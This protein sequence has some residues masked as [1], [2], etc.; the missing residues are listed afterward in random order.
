MINLKVSHLFQYV[1]VPVII[2]MI[3]TIL[4]S[5]HV[6]D[7]VLYTSRY[8]IEMEHYIDG[9]YYKTLDL[10]ALQ[11]M[12]CVFLTVCEMRTWLLGSRGKRPNSCESPGSVILL[13]CFLRGRSLDK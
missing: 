1:T 5:Y 7:A 4:T 6:P 13:T 3:A 9:H 12:A 10:E 2:I 11:Y 8:Y